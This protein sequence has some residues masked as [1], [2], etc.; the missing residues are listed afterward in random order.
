MKII[1]TVTTAQINEKVKS[2]SATLL[3]E[4]DKY[5]DFLNY[6]NADWAEELSEHQG[7]LIKNGKNDIEQ[8]KVLSNSEAKEK[9]KNYINGKS[10]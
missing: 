4:V 2:L 1:Q 5:I 10:L 9:I 8:N 7:Q 3:Q 6:K